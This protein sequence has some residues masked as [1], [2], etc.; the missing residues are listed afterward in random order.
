MST[1][2]SLMIVLTVL[3]LMLTAFAVGLAI[4]LVLA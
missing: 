3:G 4:G 2:T 1:E